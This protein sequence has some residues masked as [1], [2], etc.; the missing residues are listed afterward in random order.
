MLAFGV[1]PTP[2]HFGLLLNI[3]QRCGLG[4][5]KSMQD[6]LFPSQPEQFLIDEQENKDSEDKVHRG[7]SFL[8][9]ISTNDEE[10]LQL[11][12]TSDD[13]TAT[14]DENQQL[15]STS[16]GIIDHYQESS[17]NCRSIFR[18]VARSRWRSKRSP[19]ERSS[20]PIQQCQYSQTKHLLWRTKSCWSSNASFTSWKTY[21][22]RWHSRC[23]QTYARVECITK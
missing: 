2:F 1:K 21:V 9:S 19:V 7:P 16:A 8:S 6:L 11:S 17:N 22:A 12:T 13:S 23:S 14:T 5:P 10:L 4:S 15:I 3:T 18:V 20:T